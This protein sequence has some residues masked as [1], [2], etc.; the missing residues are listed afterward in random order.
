M[1]RL[2]ACRVGL[3]SLGC[4]PKSSSTSGDCVLVGI[5]NVP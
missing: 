2:I 5:K 1:G 4:I 3:C